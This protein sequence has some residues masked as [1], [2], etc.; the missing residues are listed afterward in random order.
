MKPV[1]VI[2]SLAAMAFL[3]LQA[4][5]P[6]AAQGALPSS[7]TWELSLNGSYM[8]TNNS[9]YSSNN[10]VAYGIE[11]A[12]LH[13][14]FA[15]DYWRVRRRH[16]SFG[17]RASY[18][19]IP[20]NIA[21]D[22]YGLV[23]LL[24]RPLS[25]RFHYTIGFGL[26]AYTK[27]FSLTGDTNNIFIGSLVNCLI[28]LS[29]SY[30]PTDRLAFNLS[31]L[32]TSNGM[33]YRPNQGLNYLQLGA[34]YTFGRQVRPPLMSFDTSQST[35]HFQR[36]E[37]RIALSLGT[38]MSRHFDVEGYFPCYDLSLNYMYF[39]SPVFSIGGTLDFW[40]NWVDHQPIVD[41]QMLH[42]FP[43]YVSAMFAFESFFGPL[44][45]KAGIGPALIVSSE[46]TIPFY[47]RVGLYY[48]FHPCHYVGVALNAHAGRV[49]F[50]EWTYGFR[51]RE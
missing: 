38:V 6:L 18:A 14:S 34:T 24:R 49:E 32:H 16:P 37:P 30:T 48:N 26:S 17:I 3:L 15:D 5:P 46:V 4:A 45:I 43:V 51:L 12:W 19:R 11:A 39:L 41:K 22:R 21:G 28:D 7:S 29:V 1:V 20:D 13:R 9:R 50:I 10:S 8:M 25:D 36:V 42:T 23:G 47:E 35:P 44:S 31:L 40:Y 2:S 33:L 27:P